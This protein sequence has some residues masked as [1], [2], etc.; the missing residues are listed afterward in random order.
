MT[1]PAPL[2]SFLGPEATPAQLLRAVAAN[3]T[4]W[5]TT[6]ALA[7][8]GGEI[9][10][11]SGAVWLY[12]P[13]PDGEVVVPFPRIPQARMAA[14]LDALVAFCRERTPRR[15][16]CWTLTPNGPRGLG[17][18]LAA[19][20]FEWGWQAH[21]MRLDFRQLSR[22]PDTLR[23]GSGIEILREEDGGGDWNV[24]DDLPYHSRDGDALFRSHARAQP[25]RA[26]RFAAWRNGKVIGQIALF[27][28]T[29]P[30]GA[31][32]IYN[33][34]VVPAARRQGIGSALIRAA[35]RFAREIGCHH[36]LLNAAAPDF[37]AALGFESLGYGQ[38]W[39]L[40]A[41]T[42]AAPPPTPE[43][44]AFAEALGLGDLAALWALRDRGALPGDLNAPL[45]GGS[46]PMTLC[47]RAQQ[48]ASAR[49]LEAQ[50]ATLE[51]LQ[52]WDFGWKN[53]IAAL[54]ARSPDLV[55]RRSGA[56]GLTPLH[57]AVSRG[58]AALVSLLLAARPDLTLEDTQFHS[59]PLGWA[60]HLQ[61]AEIIPLLEQAEKQ[62]SPV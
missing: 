42:L 33:M 29:G 46:P 43:Q 18:R 1:D 47:V 27:V 38:T 48:P 26:W 35:C 4:A 34:G 15:V 5:F 40:H 25:R 32:G 3:H 13:G 61:K 10:R 23:S 60:R 28:T 54:L 16:S 50:G 36:A 51:V 30:P 62:A 39:W 52:A 49:W 53:Q 44:I 22:L 57:E 56:W 8:P 37:Y 59:T 20:G 58:D 2:P 41:P 12:T 55:N 21:W 14:T 7:A 17:A 45:P 31:A 19:R 6:N 11:R 9:C 24:E